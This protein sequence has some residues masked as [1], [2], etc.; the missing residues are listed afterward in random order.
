MR[1]DIVME[2]EDGYRTIIEV[3]DN[4]DSVWDNRS[5][6]LLNAGENPNIVHIAVRALSLVPHH[7]LFEGPTDPHW[8]RALVRM[9]FERDIN[10][11]R[12][13]VQGYYL[14]LQDAGVPRF[15]DDYTRFRD[16]LDGAFAYNDACR[17]ALAATA[18]VNTLLDSYEPLL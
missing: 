1:F 5:A 8:E 13:V 9:H 3:P 17:I 2:Q 12:D 18:R 4:G 15:M 10:R 6:I 14:A 7:E 16:A 11:L